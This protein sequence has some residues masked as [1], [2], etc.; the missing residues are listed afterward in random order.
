MNK[1]TF[2]Y[3]A[4]FA[5][6]LALAEYITKIYTNGVSVK[7]SLILLLWVFYVV[8]FG[9]NAFKKQFGY[10][11]YANKKRFAII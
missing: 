8:Y 7:Q 1:K 2:Y 10:E 6:L 11:N 9:I 5:G 4:F 3:L